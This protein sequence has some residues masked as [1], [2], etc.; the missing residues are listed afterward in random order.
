MKKFLI[1][2]L[3]PLLLMVP[4]TTF[5]QDSLTCP[6]GSYHGLDNSGNDACR[7][8]ETN[9]VVKQLSIVQK[10]LEENPSNS[11]L[12]VFLSFFQNLF[13]GFSSDSLEK[14]VESVSDSVSTNL[15]SLSGKSESKLED[16]SIYKKQIIDHT[17]A[18]EALRALQKTDACEQRNKQI[19][20]KQGTTTSQSGNY[21]TVTLKM[22]NKPSGGATADFTINTVRVVDSNN[23]KIININ[24]LM[25]IDM[26]LNDVVFFSPTALWMLKSPSGEVYYEQCHG[27]QY[28]GSM[29][30]GKDNPN[31]T[32]DM[33][34]HV[35]K[36]LNKFDLIKERAKIGTIILD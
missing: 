17:D 34:F 26:D 8:I 9:K 19:T 4:G 16:C 28:D 11:F 36:D 24:M 29:I 23:Y 33:C 21:P 5:A 7:D 6:P 27:R 20:I 1:L 35:E 14:S 18:D 25:E 32:W 10:T 3:I 2:G 13:K 15:E 22:D 30:T 12:D 31:R